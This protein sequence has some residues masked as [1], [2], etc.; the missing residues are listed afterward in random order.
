[1][2][3]KQL[4]DLPSM[5]PQIVERCVVYR[6]RADQVQISVEHDLKCKLLRDQEPFV[7]MNCSSMRHKS[8]GFF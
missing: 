1:M 2:A 6:Y 3:F 4:P 7:I 5:P 8:F